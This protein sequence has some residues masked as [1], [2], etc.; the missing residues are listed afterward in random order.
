MNLAPDS[1]STLHLQRQQQLVLIVM[2]QQQLVLIV[3]SQ[4]NSTF[5]ALAIL[6]AGF[7]VRRTPLT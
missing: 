3:M 6:A 7:N 5:A 4:I 1:D 2:S